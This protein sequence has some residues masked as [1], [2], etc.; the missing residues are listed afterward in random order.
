M[1][2]YEN[3]ISYRTKSLRENAQR[4]EQKLCYG[5]H[6]SAGVYE[7]HFCSNFFRKGKHR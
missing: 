7:A 5:R 3:R 4:A 6:Q 2:K 1:L